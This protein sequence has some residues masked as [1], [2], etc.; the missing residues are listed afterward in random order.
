[1]V[2][3]SLRIQGKLNIRNRSLKE[4]SRSHHQ[5]T[6]NYTNTVSSLCNFSEQTKPPRKKGPAQVMR[7][8]KNRSKYSDPLMQQ[9]ILTKGQQTCYFSNVSC[10][11]ASWKKWPHDSS[12]E[13]ESMWQNNEYYN[14]Q[15]TEL[16]TCN[17]TAK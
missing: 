1:M 6:E 17:A 7:Q 12:L 11:V 2:Q 15:Q 9:K 3:G 14:K 13:T 5:E 8:I 4:H 10:K 16:F